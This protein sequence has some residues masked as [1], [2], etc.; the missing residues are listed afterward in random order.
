MI[1][2]NLRIRHKYQ[3]EDKHIRSTRITQ[4]FVLKALP[5]PETS[6]ALEETYPSY[7]A[8]EIKQG[9]RFYIE[10]A[11]ILMFRQSP[12]MEVAVVI[13]RD[14]L[15]RLWCD[16]PSLPNSTDLQELHKSYDLERWSHSRSLF[17]LALSPSFDKKS[18]DIVRGR[19]MSITIGRVTCFST[20]HHQY[21]QE[22]QYSLSISVEMNETTELRTQHPKPWP[23]YACSVSFDSKANYVVFGFIPPHAWVLSDTS[24]GL[25]MSYRLSFMPSGDSGSIILRDVTLNR[26]IILTIRLRECKIYARFHNI[27]SSIL[28][29]TRPYPGTSEKLKVIKISCSPDGKSRSNKIT[30]RV[31]YAYGSRVDKCSFKESKEQE[32]WDSDLIRCPSLGC[33]QERPCKV[34]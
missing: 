34:C 2:P 5:L 4:S 10:T 25:K 29:K 23:R 3:L 27:P 1:L 21:I 26:E 13:G 19:R 33:S 12:G 16:F 32:W 20:V 30:A 8:D 11:K 14:G 31:E 22:R 24:D 15:E 9:G 7:L 17:N 28:S 18:I 6:F